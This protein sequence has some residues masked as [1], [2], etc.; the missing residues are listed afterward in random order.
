MVTRTQVE[1]LLAAASMPL[2]PAIVADALGCS[3]LQV[4]SH[5]LQLERSG[6]ARQSRSR[7]VHTQATAVAS[8]Q[9]P[10]PQDEPTVARIKQTR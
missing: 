1:R 8:L 7:W 4:E 5:L 3:R 2:S 10:R 6:L 9:A